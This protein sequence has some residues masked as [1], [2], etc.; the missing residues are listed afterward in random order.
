VVVLSSL[1]E[2]LVVEAASAS[3]VVV[4]SPSSESSLPQALRPTTKMAAARV[5]RVRREVIIGSV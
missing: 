3:V 2:P 1:S 4:V 5:A